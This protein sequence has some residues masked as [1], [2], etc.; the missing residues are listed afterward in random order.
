M[1]IF[2]RYH[3]QVHAC[4][5][6]FGTPDLENRKKEKT[7]TSNAY[8]LDVGGKLLRKKNTAAENLIVANCPLTLMTAITGVDFYGIN[9]TILCSFN[10]PPWVSYGIFTI[11]KNVQI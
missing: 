6:V 4:P 9:D 2:Q 10:Y 8:V 7:Q 11:E 1:S 3:S 5:A